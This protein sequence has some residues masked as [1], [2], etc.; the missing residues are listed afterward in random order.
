MCVTNTYLLSH[1][2][3]RCILV[4]PAR[5]RQKDTASVSE[6]SIYSGFDLEVQRVVGVLDFKVWAPYVTVVGNPNWYRYR[7]MS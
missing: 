3:Y 5:R 4:I 6:Q 7:G 1:H 2:I